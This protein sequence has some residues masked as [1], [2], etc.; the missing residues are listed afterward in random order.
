MFA[1]G[2]LHRSWCAQPICAQRA[3]VCVFEAPQH[4]PFVA[5]LVGATIVGSIATVWHGIVNPIRPGKIAEWTY[6]DQPV[7]LRKGE[8]FGRFLLESTIVL[9]FGRGTIEFND[10]WVPE[11]SGRLG[12]MMGR[13]PA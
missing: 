1:P 4:G 12:E 6:A 8:G 5:V 7:A 9:L 3:V 2:S 13:S 11:R 10:G